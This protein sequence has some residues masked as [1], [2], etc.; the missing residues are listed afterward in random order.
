M[1]ISCDDLNMEFEYENQVELDLDNEDEVQT[2]PNRDPDLVPTPNPRPKWDHKVIENVGN[3]LGD[4]LDKRRT[5]YHFQDDNLVLCH[6]CPL[7]P[8][9]C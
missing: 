3:M 7:I 6:T 8:K 4:T 2:A 1:M 5:K 9:R